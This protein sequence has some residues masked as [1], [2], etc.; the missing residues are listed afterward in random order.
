MKRFLSFV[1]ML[2]AFNTLFAQRDT[3][4]WFA[5]YYDVSTGGVYN[6]VLYFSTDATTPFEVKIYN[7]NTV[8]GTVNVSKGSPQTFA[9]N[10]NLIRTTAASSAAVPTNLGVYTKG[11]RPYF[12]SLRAA[13]SSHGEIITSKGKAGIGTKFYAA[14]TPVTVAATD[15][16]F[17]TGILATEDNTT[18]TVS[19]YDPNIS[20]VNVPSPTP[21][22]MTVNLNKGQSYILTGLSTTTPVNRD[23]FIGAKIESNKPISVTNGNA[24]GFY[25][26]TT[27]SDGADLIM[28][29]SVPTD[30]LGNEF[31]MVKSISTSS[32]NMEGGIIIATENDTDIYLNN[33]TAPV[34]TIDEGEYYRILANEYKD[35]GGGHSNL[36][37]RTTKNVYLYQLV[38]AFS[39]NNTGGFNYIPP[40]NCF[41]PR[42]IDEIG[43]INVMPNITS[44][45]TLK[46]NILTEVGAAVTVNGATPTA[47]QGPYPLTGNTQWVT[48]A[49]TGITGNVTIT[50]TKAVTAGV[51]GGYS[52]AGYGG[53][54][55]GFSS[56]PLIAKQTGDCIPGIILEVDDS[57]DT[58]QWFLNGTAIPGANSNTYSPTVA[59][60]YTVR[61]TVGSCPPAVTPVY[62]V[63]TCL[64]Q[65]TKALTVCEGFKAIIPEF[66]NSTQSYVPSTVTIV[67]PPTNGTVI[68]DPSGVIGY[69]PN[70]GFTGTDTIV[71]KFCGNDPDFTDCEQVTLTLTVS[72]SPVVTDASL[73]SCFIDSNPATALFN[74]TTAAVTSQTGIVKQYYPSPT[75]AQNGTNEILNPTA[76]IAPNGVVYIKVSNANGCYRIAKVTLIVLP[77]VYSNILE[78]KIICI[79]DMTTLDAGPGFTAY[80]WSTGATTQSINNVGAGTYWVDLKTGTCVT[81]QTVK[82]YASE[83]PVISNIDIS[84][85]TVTVNVVGGTAPYQYSMDNINWQDSNV[86][87]NVP[88]GNSMVYIKDNYNCEP[89]DVE[90]TVPNLI[91]VITPNGDGIND[92]LDYSALSHKP[93]FVFNIY[94]RYGTKLHEGNKT[95]GYKWNGTVGGKKVSTG[96]Y[97]FDLSWNEPNSKQTPIK[98]SGWIMVKNRE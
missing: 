15:K 24:N 96:N 94:D 87:T 3:D 97:W 26:T 19:G 17:T 18:V 69:T 60:N 82:V 83:Q 67:T 74:L 36:Y 49:I 90:I 10:A 23:G 5:P 59:G 2:C 45:I 32:A 51:N 98:Y 92:V 63:F 42:K 37:V 40:L 76:Y 7:N 73:R 85:N 80:E 55:A 13:V 86:F 47:A 93:N 43:R 88:R 28:D 22:T 4:H 11:D 16:N 68:V 29:Q 6:H 44:A 71:Y 25:A 8:I 31:A 53:Y 81:R 20:F 95:S 70:F 38:G 54:F 21:L 48:Y 84:N 56:I 46:L 35:Q 58:Y 30:R 57:Y 61:I 65:S 75:D 72:E 79:E 52:S 1:L 39:A 91:N 64:H 33:A 50:S 77:P 12:V 34:A 89:I 78:D 27:S 66:T 41:L 14:A 9:L 62:K